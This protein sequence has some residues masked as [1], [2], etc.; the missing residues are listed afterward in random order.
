M[1]RD[2]A[3][4]RQPY[5]DAVDAIVKSVL[6]GPTHSLL[7]IGSGD[8]RRIW[9]IANQVG[10]ERLVLTDPGRV[11]SELCAD[12]PVA[13]VIRVA[14]EDLSDL[15]DRFDGI[16]CLW[17]V[18]GHVESSSLRR[19]ALGHMKS[20][21]NEDGR[22]LLDVNNRYNARA[23][24]WLKTGY[25]MLIDLIRPSE[26]NGDVSYVWNV[27]GRQIN[28]TGHVF[29][30]AEIEELFSSTGLAILDRIVLDYDTGEECRSTF[31]GQLLYV[32]G[33]ADSQV[34]NG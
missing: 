24:G 33:H 17:N 15:D 27:G 32:L 12:L 16:T 18:L 31:Q 34:A 29:R 4:R 9:Q 3:K 19:T 13:K 2:Y 10:V 30:P 11:M 7:D 26:S 23:Y 5:L 22:I 25:R 14:A 8:G 20:R 6:T 1:Y 21:L 28:A